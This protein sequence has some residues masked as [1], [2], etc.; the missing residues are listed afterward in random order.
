MTIGGPPSSLRSLI[1]Y[2]DKNSQ[3]SKPGSV[4]RVHVYAPYHAP[5]L[6]T[7]DSIVRI[8]DNLSS[9]NEVFHK[10]Q[11][12][13]QRRTLIGAVSGQYY[14]A[15][16]RRDLL[17]QVLFNV[18]AE[19]IYWEK[20]LDG[21]KSNVTSSPNRNWVIRPFG[22]ASAAQGLFATL[23]AQ[24]NAGVRLD[25]TFGKIRAEDAITKKFPIAIIGMAGRFPEANN[26]DALWKILEE[27]LDCHKVVSNSGDKISR[28]F[29]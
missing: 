6:Y 13:S 10:R 26:H 8:L 28:P 20:V 14:I 5:R 18:L 12:P 2:L 22:P 29:S 23:K 4:H 27:G 17:E 15:S 21:C 1:S 3:S 11:W 16:S 25:E 9:F 19:P 24:E 7:R